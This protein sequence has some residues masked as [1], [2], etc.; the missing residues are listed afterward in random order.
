V[1]IRDI[2]LTRFLKSHARARSRGPK[3]PGFFSE[4]FASNQR[5]LR[6]PVSQSRRDR[7]RPKKP[8][9]F[10]EIFASNQR[11]LRNP[12]SQSR[13]DRFRPKKPGFCSGTFRSNQ[14]SLQTRFLIRGR[15]AKAKETGF[16]LRDFSLKSDISPNPVSQSRRDR[17]RPKKPG[18]FSEIFASN[19]RYLSKPGF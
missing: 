2:A 17:F 8:G 18:F 1:K 5:Y 12:V 6:N 13:R 15:I 4:I 7:F 14:I 10:S 19:Q 16:L 9:F 3:K 11:Y